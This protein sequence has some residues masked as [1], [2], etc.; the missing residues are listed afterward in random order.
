MKAVKG[1]IR[2]IT[3]NINLKA[4][5]NWIN[6]PNGFIY[7]GGKYHLFYQYFPYSASWGTMHWGHAVSDDLVSWQHLGIALYPSKSYDRNGVF[8]GSAIEVDNK[9]YMYYTA[10]VYDAENPENI[11]TSV[12]DHGLQSQA[13]IC[14]EDGF[15]FDNI[16]DKKQII[17]TI[18]DTD[19]ADPSDCRDPKVWKMNG[20]YYMCLASTHHRKKGVL[21]IYESDDA[22]SWRYLNRL[23][24]EK[25]GHTLECPDLFDFDEKWF[26]ICSPMGNTKGKSAYTD[27]A[28]IQPVRFD[29][30]SGEVVIGAEGQFLDYGFDLYA[31]QSNIDES[32]RR[33]IMS[34]AR[35][36]CAM[37]PDSNTAASSKKW[38]G[39][40]SIPRVFEIINGEIYTS[41]HPNIRKYFDS[42]SC[43]KVSDGKTLMSFDENNCQIKTTIAEGQ[44]YTI[45]GYRI[46]LIDGHV[47]GDRSDIVPKGIDIHLKS[48]TPYVGE[49]CELEIYL[50][51]DIIEIFVDGGRYAL[52]HVLYK[53]A[54]I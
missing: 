17:P 10:V 19:I 12:S 46:G 6:D 22:K 28:I 31:P 44:W 25:L 33:V 50:E 9:L 43:K 27:Q 30:K 52:S 5:G 13:M 1:E 53:N 18:E 37:K 40:M 45:S 35:M 3:N 51:S 32:G 49:S 14:S 21:V 7:Y 42:D 48:Q 54:D 38:N 16:N 15:Y 41:P 20:R 29:A 2:D 8:S 23:E 47:V 11:H 34:W 36:K 4:P 24:S 26:L 39:M